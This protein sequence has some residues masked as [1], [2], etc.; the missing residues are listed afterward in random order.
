MSIF[1]YNLMV[2]YLLFYGGPSIACM[3]TITQLIISCVL[4]SLQFATHFLARLKLLKKLLTTFCTTKTGWEMI[5][6]LIRWPLFEPFVVHWRN[7][8]SVQC[9]SRDYERFASSTAV[10]QTYCAN[11]DKSM[12]FSTII[13]YIIKFIFRCRAT[14]DL[15]WPVMTWE[16]ND[17]GRRKHTI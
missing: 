7:V 14:L 4:H 16:V 5:S 13:L 6:R 2:L 17:L 9:S 15:T 12:K 11:C 8:V 1:P 10:K 3:N